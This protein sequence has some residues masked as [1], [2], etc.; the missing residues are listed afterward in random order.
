VKEICDRVAVMYAG[1]I[2]ETGT[3]EE[4][5]R[6]PQH[7]YTR[8]LMAAVPSAAHRRGELA[9]IVGNVPELVDPSPSCRFNTRCPFAVEICR[10]TDPRTIAIGNTHSVACFAYESGD[11]GV[12]LPRL[13]AWVS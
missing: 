3:T 8:G 4:I 6:N 13:E 12:E 10:T 9:S 7:P 1:R 5:F 2:V 11:S